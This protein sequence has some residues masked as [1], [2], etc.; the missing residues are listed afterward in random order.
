MCQNLKTCRKN[1]FYNNK[2]IKTI[3][4]ASIETMTSQFTWVD[5]LAGHCDVIVSVRSRLLVPEAQSVIAVSLY[6]HPSLV[7]PGVE[8]IKLYGNQKL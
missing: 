6:Q 3:L 1:C 5:V 4:N 2:T 7:T 8:N